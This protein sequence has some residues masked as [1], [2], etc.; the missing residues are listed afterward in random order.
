MELKKRRVV[1]DKDGEIKRYN[2]Y[3]LEIARYRTQA[4]ACELPINASGYYTQQGVNFS[5]CE[6]EGDLYYKDYTKA[7]DFSRLKAGTLS[8]YLITAKKPEDKSQKRHLEAFLMIYQSNIIKGAYYLNP[9][10]F[11]HIEHKVLQPCYN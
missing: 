8:Y 9:K 11:K 3:G 1:F 10:G 2:A 7:W 5:V 6:G 4:K